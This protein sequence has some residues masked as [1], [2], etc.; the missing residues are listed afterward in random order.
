[1]SVKKF[2]VLLPLYK[3]N[4]NNLVIMKN[5]TTPVNFEG[6]FRNSCIRL[7]VMQFFYKASFIPYKS[8]KICYFFQLNEHE[9]DFNS[10]SFVNYSPIFCRRQLF[11][12]N[13]FI[14][15]TSIKMLFIKS[16]YLKIM[17]KEK[18]KNIGPI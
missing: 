7:F 5:L 2:S 1:M 3:K 13:I 16:S 14:N 12:K 17:E 10:I 6:F 15:L 4:P 9:T 11:L 8:A 18:C